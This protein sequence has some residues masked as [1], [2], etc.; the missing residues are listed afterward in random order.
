MT[1]KILKR[2]VYY[3][4]GFGFR[5]IFYKDEERWVGHCLE[6]DTVAEGMTPA[7]A[8]KN[9]KAA[10]ELQFD[11]ALAKKD[12]SI[13]YNPAPREYWQMLP[14]AIPMTHIRHYSDLEEMLEQLG[15]KIK[16]VLEKGS[17]G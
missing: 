9:L 16:K 7:D 1:T 5:F 14:Q 4:I 10:I 17:H 13:I 12:V 15:D 11:D 6:T 8:V 2:T 3:E